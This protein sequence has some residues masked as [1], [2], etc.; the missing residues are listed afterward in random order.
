MQTGHVTGTN[1]LKELKMFVDNIC[2]INK[3]AQLFTKML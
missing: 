3:K 2:R 1:G